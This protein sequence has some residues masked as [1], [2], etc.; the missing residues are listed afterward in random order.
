M[1]RLKVLTVS[2]N[3][4]S[5]GLKSMILLAD[6]AQGYQAL[7]NEINLRPAGTFLNVDTSNTTEE[8]AIRSHLIRC[9]YE[10]ITRLPDVPFVV[11]RQAFDAFP[12]LET[13]KITRKRSEKIA[14]RR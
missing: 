6:N 13:K 9:G 12:P 11:A 2:K 1:L 4:N 7:T 10:C 3:T 5:F 14:K 8:L